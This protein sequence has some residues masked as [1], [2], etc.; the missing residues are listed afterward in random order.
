MPASQQMRSRSLDAHTQPAPVA[1]PILDTWPLDCV[2]GVR[3]GL[4]AVQLDWHAIV[5]I[6]INRIS[7]HVRQ[8]R[9]QVL[10]SLPVFNFLNRKAFTPRHILVHILHDDLLAVAV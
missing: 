4:E 5:V 2:F 7:Q 6:V 8:S 10:P 1:Y 9:S 3:F